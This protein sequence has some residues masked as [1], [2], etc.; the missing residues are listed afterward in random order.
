MRTKEKNFS[1]LSPLNNDS[2]PCS[3]RPAWIRYLASLGALGG[4]MEYFAL[5]F[6]RD[7]NAELGVLDFAIAHRVDLAQI[8]SQFR[9]LVRTETFSALRRCA[10][11]PAPPRFPG[12]QF[13]MS[14]ADPNLTGQRDGTR[15]QVGGLVIRGGMRKIPEKPTPRAQLRQWRVADLQEA[16]L[17]ADLPRCVEHLV[18]QSREWEE[19]ERTSRKTRK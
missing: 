1:S 2:P 8:A 10:P 9:E 11:W 18:L 6:L 7:L 5:G 17:P 15:T 4:A 3:V 14:S 12:P 13:V 19:K 16:T